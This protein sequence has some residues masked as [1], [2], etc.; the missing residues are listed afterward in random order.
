M[1]V[2]APIHMALKDIRRMVIPQK[3]NG[4][5]PMPGC[6]HDFSLLRR[7]SRILIKFGF[8]YPYQHSLGG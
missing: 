2:T 3:H 7:L 1:S 6:R 5:R 8:S 4:G